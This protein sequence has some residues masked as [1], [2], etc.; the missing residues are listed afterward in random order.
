MT[1]LRAAS[2]ALAAFMGCSPATCRKGASTAQLPPDSG[3]SAGDC[4]AEGPA[5]GEI[6]SRIEPLRKGGRA[7]VLFA[8]PSDTEEQAFQQWV[9]AVAAA[10]RDGGPPPAVAPPGFAL[11]MLPEQGMWLLHEDPQNRRGAGAIVIRTGQAN[12]LVVQAPHTFFDMGTLPIAVSLF[13][14]QKARA[15]LISTVH[16]HI[17]RAAAPAEEHPDEEEDQ[18]A[19]PSPSDPAHADRSFFLAAHK[20]LLEV[21]PRI[22]SVQ[23]H[24]FQDRSVPGVSVIVSAAGTS[25]DPSRLAGPLRAAFAGEAVRT[26]PDEIRQ[27]GALSNVQARWS[28]RVG[29][30]LIHIEISRSLRD[31]LAAEPALRACFSAAFSSLAA[32]ADRAPP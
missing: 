28:A 22:A 18:P 21:F 4:P 12:P 31:R 10:A 8:G 29:A 17:A 26:Y 27:L 11:Q 7:H 6:L 16:R 25:A 23:V 14:M 9:V 2:I 32:P 30:P 20:A 3:A 13:D 1:T 15:L 24:G 19:E 5:V